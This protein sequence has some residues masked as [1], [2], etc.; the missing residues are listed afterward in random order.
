MEAVND[1]WANKEPEVLY[2]DAD[3]LAL[4]K[5]SGLAVHGDGRNPRPTLADW[6]AQKYPTIVGVGEPMRRPDGGEIARPG[7]VHRLDRETSGVIVIAKTKESFEYLKVAFQERH[8]EKKYLAFVHGII[9]ED[10]G[11]INRPIGTSRKDFRLRSAQRGAKGV[12]REALTEYLVLKRGESVTYVEVRP[13]TG[14]THQIRVHFKAI[15][16]PVLCDRL[17]APKHAELLGFVRL[18]L[19]AHTI[20]FTNKEGKSIT[21]EAPLPSDFTAALSALEA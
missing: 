3:F 20:A 11:V 21:V 17:Y 15:N 8:V 5:P 18:A 12:M 6:I 13:K 10:D 14:R 1:V 2:E 19:H 7:I 9:K 16:H 4:N